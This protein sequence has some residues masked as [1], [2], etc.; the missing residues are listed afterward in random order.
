MAKVLDCGR[1][2]L[3]LLF[4][5]NLCVNLLNQLIKHEFKLEMFLS[6]YWSNGN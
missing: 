5:I 2:I 4:Y 1:K 3:V 6:V